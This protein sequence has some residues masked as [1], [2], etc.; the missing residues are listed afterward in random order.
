MTPNHRYVF[1]ATC[2]LCGQHFR[3]QLHFNAHRD[4]DLSYQNRKCLSVDRITR[5]DIE[6]EKQR[7]HDTIFSTTFYPSS[8]AGIASKATFS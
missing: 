3:S 1:D 2:V 7:I 8:T 4:I 6:R 5:S